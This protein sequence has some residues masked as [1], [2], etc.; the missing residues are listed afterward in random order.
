MTCTAMSGMTSHSTC[1]LP[2][3][4]VPASRSL[5]PP[6]SGSIPVYFGSMRPKDEIKRGHGAIRIQATS[7]G[8]TRL[9]TGGSK[10]ASVDLVQHLAQHSTRP[11]KTRRC[12]SNTPFTPCHV[13][14][15]VTLALQSARVI[16][17]SATELK[18][19]F[20]SL[21]TAF[22]SSLT[23]GCFGTWLLTPD[24]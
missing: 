8:T 15:R 4:S 1:R 9:P 11:R 21:S 20:L 16:M 14:R 6:Q 2:M 12:L 17:S 13:H 7:R 10:S 5:Q 19:W 22:P 18:G 23:T 3:C 24:A